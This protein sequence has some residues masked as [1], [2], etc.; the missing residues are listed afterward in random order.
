MTIE[1]TGLA[2]PAT[3][4]SSENTGG[5]T[6]RTEPAPLQKSTGKGQVIE[7]VT[8]SE[9]AKQ[10]REL[11]NSIASVPVVDSLRVEQIKQSLKDGSY[12][13]DSGRVAIKYL[14]FETQL[15]C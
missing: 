11:E 13:F 10:I 15:H 8:L 9:F 7:T 2:T 12:D 5:L 6:A 3:P 14:Q 1:I 4:V